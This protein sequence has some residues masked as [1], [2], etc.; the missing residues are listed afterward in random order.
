[1]SL[2]S[3]ISWLI[4]N[5][6]PFLHMRRLDTG[7]RN[8]VL[9]ALM[10]W[11]AAAVFIGA[12]GFAAKLT[13]PAPQAILFG[14]VLLLFIFFAIS[15][16]FR[17]WIMSVDI[18]SLVLIHVSRFVGIYFLMLYAEGRLPY[19]FAV[20]GGWGDIVVASGAVALAAFCPKEGKK[21]RIFY[22][23]WN[24]SGLVDILFVVATAASLAMANPE[25]MSELLKLPLWLLPSFL[26]P[27]IIFTHIIVFVRLYRGRLDH[28]VRF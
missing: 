3:F 21:G 16:G 9:I 4:D 7:M 18:R 26:V 22:L 17:H 20:P 19:D 2:Y 6:I 23:I 8:K 28:S 5:G 11:I 27:V 15:S 14:L 1:M 13:P 24:T 10:I 12:S 25:S